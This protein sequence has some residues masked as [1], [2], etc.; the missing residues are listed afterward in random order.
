M[1]E[2]VE[3]NVGIKVGLEGAKKA[4]DSLTDLGDRAQRIQNKLNRMANWTMGLGGLAGIL[5]IGSTV[6]ELDEVHEAVARVSRGFGE[7]PQRVHALTRWMGRFGVDVQDATDVMVQFRKE[8]QSAF[9]D[10][11]ATD[12]RK[13]FKRMGINAESTSREIML[14]ISKGLT[15]GRVALDRAFQD[16]GMGDQ[17]QRALARALR[18][19]PEQL[20]KQ[21]DTLEKSSS[22]ITEKRLR[23]WER[24]E[25]ARAK[26]KQDWQDVIGVLYTT[27]LPVVA[28]FAEGLSGAFKDAQPKMEAFAN[29]LVEHMEIVVA[30][31]KTFLAVMT[32]NK[33]LDMMGMGGIIGATKRLQAF[34]TRSMAQRAADVTA[35][36]QGNRAGY[37]VV[38][39]AAFGPSLE[40][41]K[42]RM[43][44]AA[45]SRPVAAI[46]SLLL[47]P[48]QQIKGLFAWILR[49]L[50]MIG[51]FLKPVLF[52]LMRL[53]VWVTAIFMVVK[54]V[55]MAWKQDLWGLRTS[56]QKHFKR[57]RAIFAVITEALGPVFNIAWDFLK[58]IGGA[59]LWIV[60]KILAVVEGIMFMLLTIGIYLKKQM[61]LSAFTSAPW[62][63]FREAMGEAGKRVAKAMD[64][65]DKKGS[66]SKDDT[67][68]AERPRT[69]QNFSGPI[70]IEAKFEEGFP[71]DL[72]VT[73]LAS[74]L[75]Q[76]SGPSI[77]HAPGFQG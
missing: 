52:A 41:K 62:T 33:L 28:R 17:E 75:A 29:F 37:N 74:E 50:R 34:G 22:A 27:F 54:G 49:G 57:I 55:I 7:A 9:A 60:D 45:R 1:A 71:P 65:F 36:R 20:Q 11:K 46:G 63:L 61:S 31:A 6:R 10:P 38:Q 2:R 14:G 21:L 26:M 40:M 8:V 48:I 15:D 42:G 25:R 39:S 4:A 35:F 56:I 3:K 70:T 23:A 16:L 24:M 47:A 59:F 76:L 5:A 53:F 18:M 30:L 66:K 73:T 51:P 64:N 69:V 43:A 12:R 68:S 32:A 44:R 19:G 58:Y 13:L 72:I 67:R 77:H